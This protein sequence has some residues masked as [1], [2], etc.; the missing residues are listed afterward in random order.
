MPR[1]PGRG[2]PRGSA[3]GRPSQRDVS[4]ISFRC[5]MSIADVV[6]A[7]VSSLTGAGVDLAPGL[8]ARELSEA[9][10]AAGC[11][12]PDDLR[13]LL[14]ECLPM[15][16]LFPDWR[17][18]SSES[19]RSRMNGPASGLIFDVERNG[20]W[21]PS[22]GPMPDSIDD[23]IEIASRALETVPGLV[24]V[25]GHR[26][27]PSEP[28]AVGNPVLSVVQSD[29]IVYGANLAEYWRHEFSGWHPQGE[30]LRSVPFWSWF[31]END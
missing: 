22:F 18:P 5:V 29:I 3:T 10:E 6:A 30:P 1:T 28:A 4:P 13:A 31:I 23:R 9:E 14:T 16:D 19:I 26:Y 25:Y 17:D 24:P 12:F 20:L 15:G 7:S 11:C 2:R 8:S 21:V 27:L